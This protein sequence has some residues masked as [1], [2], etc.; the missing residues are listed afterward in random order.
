MEHIEL[1]ESFLCWLRVDDSKVA[2][3]LLEAPPDVWLALEL[4]CCVDAHV[5]DDLERLAATRR[6][7]SFFSSALRCKDVLFGHISRPQ[8]LRLVRLVQLLVLLNV[9][10]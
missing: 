7:E 6:S 10:D 1:L 9:L 4:G 2:N 5:F 3:V 8:S